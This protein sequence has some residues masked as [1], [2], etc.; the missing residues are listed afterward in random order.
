MKRI[1]LKGKRFGR[2]KVVEYY[3]TSKR[4][5]A[6]WLCHCNCGGTAVVVSWHL[7]TGKTKSCGCIT[8]THG[9]TVNSKPTKIFRIWDS[10][11]QRCRNPNHIF[12]R[13]YGGAGVRVCER[14]EKFENFLE[15]MGE[16][17]KGRSLDRFPTTSRLYSKKT[18]RWATKKQQM[19]N[20]APQRNNLSGHKGVCKGKRRNTWR[21]HIYLNGKVLSLGVFKHIKDAAL[22][23]DK[24]AYQAW[25]E[26][27]YL[28]FPR[29]KK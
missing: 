24:A 15:D 3:G 21:S 19:R 22:V 2:L 17:P 29:K 14:W 27:A 6:K 20:T 9:H 18:C 26:D 16:R 12:Y 25:G 11:I 7:R 10:M 13:L 5:V 4:K 8:K 28:N 1:E 23:Y